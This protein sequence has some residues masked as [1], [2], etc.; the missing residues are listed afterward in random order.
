M[1]TELKERIAQLEARLAD[2]E[3]RLPK[4]STPAAM[5]IELEEIED[6]LAELRAQAGRVSDQ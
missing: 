6:E 2:L 4:H 1:S 3:A 5:V